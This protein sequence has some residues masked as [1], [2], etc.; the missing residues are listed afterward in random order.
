MRNLASQFAPVLLSLLFWCNNTISWSQTAIDLEFQTEHTKQLRD[1]AFS[2]DRK[3]A[4]TG[5]DDRTIKIW[6]T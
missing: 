4:A 1:I 3:Y 2:V 6:D 5:S